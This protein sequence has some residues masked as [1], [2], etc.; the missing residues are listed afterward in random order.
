MENSFRTVG[1]LAPLLAISPHYD[2]AVF[3]CA[4][5]LN[6]LP[7][8]MVVTVFTACPSRSGILTDWD[9]RCGFQNAAQAMDTRKIENDKAMALLQATAIDLNFLD[10]QYAEASQNDSGL[11][12]D[13]LATTLSQ[14]HPST[15]VFP[16][17][18]FHSDHINVSDVLITLSPRFADITWIAYE[19]IPYCRQSAHVQARVAQLSHRDIV[20]SPCTVLTD[21][22]RFTRH[23]SVKERAVNA[24]RSQ[25][26]GLGHDSARTILQ[27]PERYWRMQASMGLL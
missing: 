7:A 8:S 14:L 1:N 11:L 22:T 9:A 21:A 23:D 27:Q 6:A 4:H 20:V 15:V 5:L 18:L 17:G 24:Y 25:F 12:L 26:R 10:D 16:L 13:S 3:S 19:D 2:D